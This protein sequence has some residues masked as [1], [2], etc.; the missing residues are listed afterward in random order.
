MDV[1]C[2]NCVHLKDNSKWNYYKNDK[3]ELCSC[4]I[5]S[6]FWEGDI[7]AE[8]EYPIDCPDFVDNKT[9]RFIVNNLV[10]MVDSNNTKLLNA[11]K[12]K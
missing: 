10:S 3:C 9:E 1:K 2:I 4:A 11:I 12:I 5:E 8:L 7:H 6:D